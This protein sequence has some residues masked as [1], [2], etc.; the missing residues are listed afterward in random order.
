M[1]PSFYKT[2]EKKTIFQVFT[3]EEAETN[4]TTS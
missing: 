1:N 2:L 4:V 3:K